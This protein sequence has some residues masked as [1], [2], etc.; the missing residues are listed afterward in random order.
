MSASY[1]RDQGDG[2]TYMSGLP[3]PKDADGVCRNI[4]FVNRDFDCG[5]SIPQEDCEFVDCDG[6]LER[7][8]RRRK[9]MSGPCMCGDNYC[10]SCGPAQGNYK[11]NVCGTWSADGG[12]DDPE[13]CAAMGG[14][15]DE[16]FARQLEEERLAQEYWEE[17]ERRES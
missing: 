2:R 6:R 16:K 4:R 7:K 10:P 14:E 13:A 15:M 1:F 12:C 3:I 8:V 9:I 5:C 17:M 11:Y